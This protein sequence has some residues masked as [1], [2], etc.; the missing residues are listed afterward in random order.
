MPFFQLNMLTGLS[1]NFDERQWV[2]QIR[3]TLDEELEDEIETP[4][5]IFAVPKALLATDPNSY[6]P[7]QVAIGPYHHMRPELHD[8]ERYKVAAAKRSQ[9]ELQTVCSL[10]EFVDRLIEHELR[11]RESYHR[12]LTFG[13]E[14][15]AWMLAVDACFLFE[16]F[17]VCG[18]KKGKILTKAPSRLS[19][20]IDLSGNKT[21]H[22]GILVD[23][24]MLENQIPLFVMRMLLESQFSSRELADEI[25]LDMLIEL[26]KELSPFKTVVCSQR[27]GVRDS[28]HLLDFLYR[29]IVP[30]SEVGSD[31]I[32]IHEEADEDKEDDKNEDSLSKSHIRQVLDQVGEILSK[33]GIV[34]RIKAIIF[35]K[36]VKVIVKLPW[37]ILSKIPIIKMMKEPI[38]NMLGFFQKDKEKKDEEEE[39][40]LSSTTNI[41]KPPL[42]EEIKIPSVSQLV[43]V[44]VHFTPTNEGVT[45]IAFD[46]KSL[47]FSIPVIDLDVNSE[48][49]L[50][51]LTAY[52]ACTV[53]GPLV[54]TRY[55]EL[56]NGIIDT[57]MDVKILCQRGIIINRLKS[58]KEVAELWNGMSK[59]VRLTKVPSLDKLI[60]DVNRYYNS[61][62]KVRFENLFKK[63]VLGSWRILAFL[64]TVLL[65]LLMG[66]QAFCQVYNC[67]RI[68]HIKALDPGNE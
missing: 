47:N 51:N 19:I 44:G 30:K 48:V 5:T 32:E 26:C 42:F 33:L 12:P 25:L 38:E 21:A 24:I 58:E 29:F 13:C 14:A 37:T 63:Y 46:P 57:E 31:T 59:S 35:S 64:A 39:S 66:L 16:F 11:I 8:M 28:A 65:L 68:V 18:V 9:K 6:I 20:L 61:R 17:Q 56:M 41:Y 3:Q 62:W 2:E 1:S 53:S 43:D 22:N 15:L 40:S 27:I 54:L 52:E 49:V 60:A 7:H 36:Q 50:R 4:V 55:V 10:Q 23:I 45:S 34:E 67:S